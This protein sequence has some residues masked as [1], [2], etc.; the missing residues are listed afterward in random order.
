MFFQGAE[1]KAKNDESPDDEEEDD[2]DLEKE[3]PKK[4]QKPQNSLQTYLDMNLAKFKKKFPQMTDQEVKRQMAKDFSKLSPEAKKQYDSMAQ[5]SK[6]E[7]S[8]KPQT[9]KTGKAST[10][11]PASTKPG[12]A[13]SKKPV[14]ASPATAP[15]PAKKAVAA[16]TDSPSSNKAGPSSTK[17]TATASPANGSKAASKVAPKAAKAATQIPDWAMKEDLYPGEPFKPYQW[18]SRLNIIKIE[19]IFL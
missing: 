18:V 7:S 9:S 11:A 4:I 1:K 19:W 6:N 15:T 5:K 8:A 2:S 17:K 16:A 12:P 3:Q 14:P 13:S 10:A